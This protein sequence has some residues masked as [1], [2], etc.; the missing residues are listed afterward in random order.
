MLSISEENYLKA[1]HKLQTDDN[2]FVN[3]NALAD[4]LGTK[5][6]SITDMLKKLAKKELCVYIKYKG[7]ELS[8]IGRQKAISI[9]RKHR[10]WELFLV[11]KLE[12]SWENVHDIA[13]QLEHIQSEEL[14][15]RL[16]TFL[17]FPNWDPHG[18]PI[19]NQ[20]GE[21]PQRES[22][23]L[24]ESEIGAEHQLIGVLSEASEFLN[25]LNVLGLDIGSSFKI[26]DKITF[27]DSLIIEHNT[28]QKQLS[29]KA[30][31]QL[32]VNKL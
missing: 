12:F 32:I 15:H 6:S 24:S 11:E 31:K 8:A 30:T 5:A 14:V 26:L 28:E 20:L 17:G 29:S 25:Y 9:V 7:V 13:E 3:T 23:V 4:E 18:N 22:Q 27:D 2:P 21:L 16:D 1:I 10:L 19:P